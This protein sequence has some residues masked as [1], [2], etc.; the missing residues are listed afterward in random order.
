MRRTLLGPVTA[1]SL[2]MLGACI[3]ADSPKLGSA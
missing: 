3:D 2:V 1:L